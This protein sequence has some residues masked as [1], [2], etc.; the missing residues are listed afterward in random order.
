M[1]VHCRGMSAA[2]VVVDTLA[3]EPKVEWRWE[4]GSGMWRQLG[5]ILVEA[6]GMRG[7]VC[8]SLPFDA[9]PSKGTRQ[10]HSEKCT[11]QLRVDTFDSQGSRGILQHAGNMSKNRIPWMIACHRAVIY[12]IFIKSNSRFP[13]SSP[14]PSPYLRLHFRLRSLLFYQLLFVYILDHHF[15]LSLRF[16]PSL[17]ISFTFLTTSYS[18]FVC[19]YDLFTW[20]FT[21]PIFLSYYKPIPVLLRPPV[22]KPSNYVVVLQ[23]VN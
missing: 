12:H 5:A 1:A 16:S 7:V 19:S 18:P 11:S 10:E 3:E 2:T 6:G 20:L 4:F 8:L 23:F 22:Y 17:M 14:S 13:P 9:C 21:S 15:I